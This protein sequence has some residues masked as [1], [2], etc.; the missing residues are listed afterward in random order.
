M[1]LC[2]NYSGNSE[3]HSYGQPV[4]GSF[5]TTTCLHMHILCRVFWRNIKSPRWLR[6]LQPIFGT[7]RLLA[8]LKTTITV[9]RVE[10]SDCQWDSGKYDTAACGHWENC[11]RSQGAYFEGDWG[12]IV[13]WIMVL[14][15]FIV[16]QV[17]F[18]PFS[19][20]QFPHSIYPHFPPSI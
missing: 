9:E 4:I 12:V 20:H 18:S 11:V 7:L 1:F 5:I 17:Q 10:I 16:V 6:P 14:V 19:R 3:D 2:G 8:F 15:F 13:P